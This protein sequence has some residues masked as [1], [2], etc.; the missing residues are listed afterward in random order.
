M[1]ELFTNLTT[2]NST[3]EVIQEILKKPQHLLEWVPDIEVINTSNNQFHIAR[4]ASALNQHEVLTIT[5]TSTTIT[6][7]STRGRLECDL[8]FKISA[9]ADTTIVEQTL[10]LSDDTA[11]PLPVTLLAPFAKHAFKQNLNTLKNLAE[12]SVSQHF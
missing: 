8:I 7:H 2:I 10:F 5:A 9:A 6:Y 1:K 11:L 12:R 4:N 3:T